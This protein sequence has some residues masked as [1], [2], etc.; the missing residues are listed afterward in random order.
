MRTREW[1]NGASLVETDGVEGLADALIRLVDGSERV[2]THPLRHE[3]A[4]ADY[5]AASALTRSA[6]AGSSGDGRDGGA[7]A[8]PASAT[9]R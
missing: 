6:V 7:G 8:S 1:S 2:I 9:S 5:A 3:P 4:R